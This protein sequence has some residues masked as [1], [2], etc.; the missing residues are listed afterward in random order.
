MSVLQLWRMNRTSQAAVSPYLQR[1]FGSSVISLW[2]RK[3]RGTSGAST[4][5][6]YFGANIDPL[7]E[8]DHI[9]VTGADA[10]DTSSLGDD[11]KHLVGDDELDA[12]EN[13]EAYRPLGRKV[14]RKG[15]GH[16]RYDLEDDVDML[17]RQGLELAKTRVPRSK[18]AVHKESEAYDPFHG[19]LP[20]AMA[21]KYHDPDVV[22]RSKEA[23]RHFDRDRLVNSVKD[24]HLPSAVVDRLAARGVQ[25]LTDLQKA[26]IPEIRTKDDVFV[27]SQPAAGKTLGALLATVPSLQRKDAGE[28][29]IAV[30]G[31]SHAMQIYRE[32]KQNFRDNKGDKRKLAMVFSKR[33]SK[34][35]NFAL[36]KASKPAIAIGQANILLQF[37]EA[38]PLQQKQVQTLILDDADRLLPKKFTFKKR[39]KFERRNV[40]RA[41][42]DD[43]LAGSAE[44]KM[45]RQSA[46]ELVQKLTPV[47]PAPEH[48][49]VQGFEAMKAA[50]QE[51]DDVDDDVNL[52]HDDIRYVTNDG[53][54]DEKRPIRQQ[55]RPQIIY[56]SSSGDI[57]FS[58]RVLD[59][60]NVKRPKLIT[61][62]DFKEGLSGRFPSNVECTHLVVPD[63]DIDQN[64]PVDPKEFA[65]NP[66]N[67]TKL[68]L[69]KLNIAGQIIAASQASE[70]PQP[71]WVFT[72][73]DDRGTEQA[74]VKHLAKWG[75][76]ASSLTTAAAS[77]KLR[78]Y[79]EA[80]DLWQKCEVPV[81]VCSYNY[82]YGL[83]IPF[84]RRAIALE[85]PS[86]VY[87]GMKEPEFDSQTLAMF[88]TDRVPEHMAEHRPIP[89]QRKGPA[90]GRAKHGPARLF[91]QAAARLGRTGETGSIL[92]LL[93]RD[94]LEGPYLDCLSPL[95]VFSESLNDAAEDE[96]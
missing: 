24:M 82:A 51:L 61:S 50:S 40:S 84:V 78:D 88:G 47:A 12:S 60:M 1:F 22:M 3:L 59:A 30:N 6:D 8:E 93:S 41:D 31:D 72:R 63:P 37:L 75:V 38:G 19:R 54:P 96:P 92:S 45:G 21:A 74:I 52:D 11:V 46:G 58:R 65:D 7:D 62:P 27:L 25:A 44:L 14:R 39:R 4:K 49:A 73:H 2:P 66:F 13:S 23:A 42:D 68:T 77:L 71:F 18:P 91:L 89:K 90:A 80:L 69:L 36:F 95:G 86:E 20:S 57:D 17:M 87:V 26:M 33:F 28:L 43:T 29:L 53:V 35:E 5:I 85:P 15:G 81:M 79:D 16:R 64:V 83:D 76:Q 70:M 48:P 10:L 94:E 56:L 67:L 55:Q 32:I 34:E 9:P